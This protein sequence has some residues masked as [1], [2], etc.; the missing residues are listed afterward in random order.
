M[1]SA[2]FP[3]RSKSSLRPDIADQNSLKVTPMYQTARYV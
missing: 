3:L 2:F 1:T